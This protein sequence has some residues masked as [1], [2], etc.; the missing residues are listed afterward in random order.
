ML[1]KEFYDSGNYVVVLPRPR[2]FGK[3]LNL[4]MIEYFFDI[5]K[6]ESANLFSEYKI[7][8]EKEFCEQHQNKYPVINI[9]LKSI[10]ANDWEGCLEKLKTVISKI[11]KE[12][13]YLL[14]SDKLENYDKEFIEKIITEQGTQNNYEFSLVNL[15]EYL[16]THFER[17]TIILLDEYDAPIIEGYRE[18]YYKKIIKFMQVFL[19]KAFKGNKTMHK[20]L[21]TGILRIARESLFSEFNNPG[22]YTITSRYF[23]DR[24]GFTEQETKEAL[25]YFGLQDNYENVKQWYDGYQFGVVQDIYNPWSIVN[26]IANCEDGFPALLDKFRYRL[27]DKRTGFRNG[28]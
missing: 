17:K 12:H 2:R 3:T 6:K 24:F 15:S 14:K 18:N 27:F 19:G 23:S 11:Y 22:V 25:A 10:K 4:S 26:Y 9:T 16:A 28:R 13:K 1:I 5:R 20:G 8:A 21:I 7:S